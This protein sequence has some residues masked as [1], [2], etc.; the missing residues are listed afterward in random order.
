MFLRLISIA[1]LI[2]VMMA[3]C[4]DGS[5]TSYLERS[6]DASGVDVVIRV[7]TF[8]NQALLNSGIQKLY[9]GRPAVEGFAAW[10]IDTMDNVRRCDIYVEEPQSKRDLYQMEIWGHELMHC[11]YGSFHEEGER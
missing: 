9:P 1:M 5:N 10:R 4:N 8:D 6:H 3:A 7:T 11:V 2:L